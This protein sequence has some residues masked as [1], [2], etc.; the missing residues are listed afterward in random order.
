M[1]FTKGPVARNGQLS[2]APDPLVCTINEWELPTVYTLAL[3]RQLFKEARKTQSQRIDPNIT[4]FGSHYLGSL[5]EFVVGRELCLPL[6]KLIYLGGDCGIDYLVKYQGWTLQVKTTKC[7]KPD[8]HLVFPTLGHFKAQCAIF[9]QIMD[10]VTMW[11]RG[12]IS[13]SRFRALAKP[14]D[15]SHGLHIAVQ[16][17]SLTSFTEFRDNAANFVEAKKDPA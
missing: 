11:I 9:V 14:T 2:F 13:Q 15:L 8:A 5:G 10:P 16:C 1:N 7:Q 6:D 3:R 12:V 4:D 17:D